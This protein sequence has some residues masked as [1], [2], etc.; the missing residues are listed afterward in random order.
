MH[1][2]FFV[3]TYYL[4][5]KHLDL[6]ISKWHIFHNIYKLMKWRLF[7]GFKNKNFATEKQKNSIFKIT[8]FKPFIWQPLWRWY[9]II[10]NLIKCKRVHIQLNKCKC[11]FS[12]L[13]YD[14]NW[15][16][17]GSNTGHS[18]EDYIQMPRNNYQKPSSFGYT[19]KHI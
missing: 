12:H 19:F 7:S 13:C 4:V 10:L 18:N 15:M 8:I 14:G 6:R 11:Q 17:E 3:L 2:F 16:F 5:I 1:V 9:R